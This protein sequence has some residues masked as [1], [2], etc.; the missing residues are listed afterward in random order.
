MQTHTT[1]GAV[2]D[3]I[4]I[5]AVNP[6]NINGDGIDWHSGARTK[7]TNSLIRSM[8]DCFA[9]FT[10]E[11]CND[12]WATNKNTAGEVKDVYIENCVLWTTLANVFRIGFNGQALSTDSITVKNRDVIHVSKGQWYA[13]WAL[14]CAVSPT[15]KGKASHRN[16]LLENIRFE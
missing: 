6:Q 7:V 8:D 14:L 16:Y 5:I 1:F 4:K 3:N 12:M 9:F 11:S 10:P 2:F 15:S 13:P